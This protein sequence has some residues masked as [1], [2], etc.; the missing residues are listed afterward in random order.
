[1]SPSP[2]ST[3]VDADQNSGQAQDHVVQKG[4]EWYA[5]ENVNRAADALES[6]DNQDNIVSHSDQLHNILPS[7]EA[8][9]IY[10]T[11][12]PSAILQKGQGTEGMHGESEETSAQEDDR[13]TR[14]GKFTYTGKHK[15]I[16]EEMYVRIPYPSSEEKQKLASRIGTN[17]DSIS[18]WFER[19][20]KASRLRGEGAVQPSVSEAPNLENGVHPGT[21]SSKSMAIQI[22]MIDRVGHDVSMRESG[23]QLKRKNI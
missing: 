1:M 12:D 15:E 8:E 9:Q 17:A 16:M 7:Q 3:M 10:S 4:Q 6:V 22:Q 14:S 18:R 5:E 2:F 19:R 23:D 13:M 21:R 11:I 20:R